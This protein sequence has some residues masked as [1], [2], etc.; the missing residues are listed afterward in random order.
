VSP[1]SR[2]VS[3]KADWVKRRTTS[4]KRM[5]W[6]PEGTD[7]ETVR[8]RFDWG[9]IYSL[10]P[11]RATAGTTPPSRRARGRRKHACTSHETSHVA[12]EE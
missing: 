9:S 1:M 4:L 7:W 12:E 2:T 11:G 5:V 10:H 6:S 8:K 3:V